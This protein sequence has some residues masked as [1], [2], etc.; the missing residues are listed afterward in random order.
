[1]EY[2]DCLEKGKIKRFSRGKSIAGKEL[3]SAESDLQMAEVSAQNKNFKW[4]TVQIYYS[5]FHSAR[6]LL[7][8]KNLREHSHY[9][10][11]R[12][13]REI[14]VTTKIV[15]VNM[16]EALKEA[17]NLREEADYYDRWSDE[18]YNRLVNK[19]GEFTNL[20]KTI[21]GGK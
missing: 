11:I 5:M 15:P 21:L 3:K 17:K 1:M 7:Y 12:A 13:I 20:V 16:L 4:A 18:G 9:C 14:Y 10:L 19:A 6:A 8:H 2:K